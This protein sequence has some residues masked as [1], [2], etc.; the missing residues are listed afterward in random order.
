MLRK[1]L[2]LTALLLATCATN[3]MA[4][5]SERAIVKPGMVI[6]YENFSFTVPATGGALQKKRLEL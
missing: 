5:Y 2:L 3:S 1:K 4:Q 6:G